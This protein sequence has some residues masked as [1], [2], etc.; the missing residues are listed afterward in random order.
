MAGSGSLTLSGSLDEDMPLTVDQLTVNVN[1]AMS[2]NLANISIRNGGTVRNGVNNALATG[3]SL[4]VGDVA[5]STS[6]TY[7]LNGFN[8]TLAEVHLIDGTISGSG[9]ILTS[10][11]NYDLHS[12]TVSARLA[13]TVG[14]VK[15]TAGTVT[16]SGNNTYS[17]GTTVDG[18]TLIVG[19]Y[20]GLGNSNL[21]INGT[22]TVQ[23][24]EGITSTNA[25]GSGAVQLDYLSIA[26]GATPTAFFDITDNNLIVHNGD[27]NTLSAQ[28]TNSLYSGFWAGEG[29][30][31]STANTDGNGDKAIGIVS[32]DDGG[33]GAFFT[34]W[35]S[36]A[37]SGGA[38][39][40]TNTDVLIRYTYFGDANL[41]G[42]TDADED[43]SLWLTGS[44]SEGALG[45]WLFGDFNYDGQ[46]DN[47]DDYALWLTGATSGGSP[48]GGGVQPVPEPS[49]L[50]LAA[51]GLAGV[52]AFARRRRVAG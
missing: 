52:A 45:G 37:D 51:L 13:G 17:G 1:S 29:I 14:V 36:G 28:V 18:G 24:A 27:F 39:S 35:P 48:L 33:G 19:H 25:A 10:S 3:S 38:V 16:L 23:L 34:S 31:S 44:T 12:G 30:G 7:N 20:H 11:S 47:S 46:V 40:T 8:Q 22:N 32:N 41:D 43:F 2:S 21:T 4:V 49:T 26:G 15:T 9:S 5:T 6:G 42:I 50:L